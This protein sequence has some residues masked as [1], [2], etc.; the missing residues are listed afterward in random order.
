MY[1]AAQ[2]RITIAIYLFSR[3]LE[4]GYNYVEDRI[5][6]KERRPWWFGSWLIMPAAC[7]Q[8]LHSFVFDRECFP[9]TYGNFILRHSSTY[10]QSRPVGFPS[11]LQ[12]PG[13]FEIVD[14]LADISRLSWPYV[15]RRS[16]EKQSTNVSPV[17]SSPR[18]S[19]LILRLSPPSSQRLTPSHLPLIHPSNISHAPSSIQMTPLACAPTYLFSPAPSPPSPNFL[20]SYTAPSH[21]C[22]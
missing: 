18:F 2:L 15:S 1:P 4:F 9:A 17:P 14:N 7:G 3:S 20:P 10:I 21:Y 16:Q 22:A 11:G 13:T 8:L 12:W 5:G 19:S 6:F